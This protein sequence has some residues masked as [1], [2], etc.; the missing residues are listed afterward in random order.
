M[1][2]AVEKAATAAPDSAERGERGR[3][4]AG[5]GLGARRR[6]GPAQPV[7]P[8]RRVPPEHPEPSAQAAALSALLLPALPARAPA[9][10]PAAGAHAGLGRD[11]AARPRHRLAGQ[12][13]LAVRHP[14][15]SHSMSSLQP[16]LCRETHH[17]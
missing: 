3:E 14:S 13:L 5:P 8:L 4:S 1:E 2:V 11:P 10:P 12:R 15:W 7:G 17:R 16:R 9:L 6:G